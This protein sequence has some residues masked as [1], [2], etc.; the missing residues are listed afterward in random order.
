MW[1]DVPYLPYA[2]YAKEQTGNI[3]TLAQ[4]EEDNLSSETRNDTESGN[5]YYDNS[6][7]AA[8]IIEEEMDAMSSGN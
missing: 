3:I 7:L 5:K 2:K 6:T 1:K 4:F 8:L